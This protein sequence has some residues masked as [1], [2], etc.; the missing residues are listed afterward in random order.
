MA[1][2]V[3]S[4]RKTVK[5]RNPRAFEEKFKLAD[6]P[7]KVVPTIS[8][9]PRLRRQPFSARVAPYVLDSMAD[10]VDPMPGSTVASAVASPVPPTALQR[11]AAITPPAASPVEGRAPAVP[12]PAVRLSATTSD[13][14]MWA[15]LSPKGSPAGAGV[16]IPEPSF[17]PAVPPFPTE[18]FPAELSAIQVDMEG[19]PTAELEDG[20]QSPLCSESSAQDTTADSETPPSRPTSNA[21]NST[22]Q[23]RRAETASASAFRW[24]QAQEHEED[25]EGP[26]NDDDL[27]SF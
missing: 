19:E 26:N 25:S 12:R 5:Q 15:E 7:T 9:L 22:R 14:Q 23:I 21:S 17:W 4:A 24:L 6:S 3:E 27:L 13:N 8:R 11:T 16:G 1:Q 20:E 2:V 18:P 10:P